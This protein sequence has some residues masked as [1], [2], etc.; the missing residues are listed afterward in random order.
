[1]CLFATSSPLEHKKD[2]RGVDVFGWVVQKAFLG[3]LHPE[4]SA[5]MRKL[6]PTLVQV[7]ETSKAVP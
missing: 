7:F 3:E 1:M 4:R 5:G 6:Q 2:S